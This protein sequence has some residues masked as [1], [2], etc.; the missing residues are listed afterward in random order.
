[1]GIPG[2]LADY[3]EL[4]REA[5]VRETM[6]EIGLNII[7]TMIIHEDSNYDESK[8]LIFI[9]LVYLCDLID[10]IK[11][12]KLQL[13]EHSEYRLISS[14]DD[15]KEEKISP[16]LFDLFNNDLKIKC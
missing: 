4:P 13:E 2:G 9:R 16:F 11:N 5:L 12:I 3:G 15:L 10:D 7:P 6:E 1:M 14:L 8:D